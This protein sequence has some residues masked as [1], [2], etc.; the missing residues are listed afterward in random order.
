MKILNTIVNRLLVPLLLLA[1]TKSGTALA[2]CLEDGHATK[3]V[4]ALPDSCLVVG[5]GLAGIHVAAEIDQFNKEN[6]NKAI[7]CTVL[8]ASGSFGGRAVAVHWLDGGEWNFLF[9]QIDKRLGNTFQ[10]EQQ[11]W[12]DI[13]FR[14]SKGGRYNQRTLSKAL[15]AWKKAFVCLQEHMIDGTAG[16][17]R[18][19]LTNFCNWDSDSNDLKRSLEYFDIDWEYAVD[20]EKI[21]SQL[22][23]L[24][25]YC[26]CC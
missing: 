24:Y 16:S 26:K 17:I 15:N 19:I 22:S 7:K 2:D 5:S 20:A 13:D 8:E 25:T 21:L 9:Q 18:D 23:L 14:T 6:P 4:D 12:S 3:E 11:A 1:T 10:Y